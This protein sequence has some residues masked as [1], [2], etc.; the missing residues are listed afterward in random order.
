[1]CLS[2]EEVICVF[3]MDSRPSYGI[4]DQSMF[5]DVGYIGGHLIPKVGR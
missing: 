4:V 5:F 3:V 2:T 1:M